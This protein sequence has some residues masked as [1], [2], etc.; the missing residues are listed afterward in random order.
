MARSLMRMISCAS[1]VTMLLV[2]GC[3][4]D[5]RVPDSTPSEG[6]KNWPQSFGEFRFRWTGEPG[7]DLTTGWAV[8][9]RAYLESWLLT[10]YTDDT[11]SVYPGFD[12]ATPPLIKEGTPEWTA[13]PYAQRSIGGYRGSSPV[14]HDS[15]TMGNEQLHILG[16]ESM[17]GGFRAL[18]CES[19]FAVYT[20]VPDSSVYRP[21]SIE[22][23]K[24]VEQADFNNMLVWRIEFTDRHPSADGAP[25][26]PNEP[27]EGPLPAPTEDVFGPWFVTGAGLVGTWSNADHPGLAPDEAKQRFLEAGEEEDRLRQQCLDWLGIPPDERLRLATTELDFPPAAEPAAPGWPG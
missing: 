2:A 10:F 7:I 9:L 14:P 16:L 8:P 4:T 25:A 5:G 13:T 20:T 3:G 17:P 27:Q 21:V 18:V 24:N 12:R 22:H 23:A 19:Q 11:R 26:S 15:V 6:P 1:V